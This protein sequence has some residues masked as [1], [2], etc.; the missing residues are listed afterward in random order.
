ML[1]KIDCHF[2]PGIAVLV[3]ATHFPIRYKLHVLSH[4]VSTC[5]VGILSQN[6]TPCSATMEWKECNVDRWCVMAS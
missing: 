6:L 4:L 2:P 3:F 5:A 1:W